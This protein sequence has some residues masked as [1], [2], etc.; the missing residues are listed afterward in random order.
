M[1]AAIG[2]AATVVRSMWRHA[3]GRFP[4]AVLGL[5]A[6]VSVASPRPEV[7]CTETRYPASEKMETASNR[8]AEDWV[9]PARGLTIISSFL[10][11]ANS[12]LLQV[13]E[14]SVESRGNRDP[15]P[16][17]GV[18]HAPAAIAILRGGVYHRI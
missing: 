12:A 9:F 13:Q 18:Y 16:A 6:A 17:E 5:W 2:Y 14:K 7:L 3:G 11:I 1:K 8:G 4:L 15:V 10:S